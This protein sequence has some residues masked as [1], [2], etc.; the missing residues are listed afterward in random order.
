VLGHDPLLP[1]AENYRRF[2]L[3]AAGRSPAYE[4]LA[5]EV[6]DEPSV[7]GFLSGLPVE[8]RQPNLL[9]AAARRLLGEPADLSSLRELVARRQNELARIMLQR[10]TQTN[11]AGRCA[12]FLPAL[13]MLTPP[14]SLIEVGAAAGLTLLPD[15]YSY[16]YATCPKGDARASGGAEG[17]GSAEHTVVGRDELAPTLRCEARGS[18]PLPAAVPEVAWRAGL[19]LAP[20][21]VDDAEDTSWLS[22]LVWPGE[23]GRAE[24]LAGAIATA[25]RHRP[26]L[27]TGDLL[28]DLAPLAAEA[29]GGTTLVVYHSAVLAYVEPARRS[30][31]SAAVRELGAVRLSCEGP[32]IEP[33]ASGPGGDETGFVLVRDGE[34]LLARADSH[35][36]WLEWSTR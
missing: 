30:A 26:L 15:Y 33:I 23:E 24:R 4:H 34:Q 8:K 10:R 18:V 3:A 31:F 35:G 25:R 32:G 2:A 19:D 20:L 17:V 6:A 16:V 36:A 14:L 1:V 21:D 11:E 22:C 7:L 12:L 13:A 9:F 5:L 27:R 29:P 28:D